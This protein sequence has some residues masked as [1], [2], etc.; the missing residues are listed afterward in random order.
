M[1]AYVYYMGYWLI[2]RRYEL[3]LLEA[4]ICLLYGILAY[5]TQVWIDSARSMHMYIIWDIGLYNAGMD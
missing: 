3:I 1:H 5:A 4:C 2:Q